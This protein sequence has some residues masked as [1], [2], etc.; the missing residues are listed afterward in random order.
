M[1]PWQGGEQSAMG[2]KHQGN[3][4][5][6]RNPYTNVLELLAIKLALFSFTKG[7]RVK[8]IDFQIDN[9]GVLSYLLKMGGT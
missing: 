7:R 9:N 8:V 5:R 1:L 4:Q 2:F 6:K 3:G